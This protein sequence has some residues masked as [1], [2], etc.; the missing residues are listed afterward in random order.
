MGLNTRNVLPYH[1]LFLTALV[2][3]NQLTLMILAKFTSTF[4]NTFGQEDIVS[5]TD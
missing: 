5:A 1:Y 2:Q 4:D 3:G